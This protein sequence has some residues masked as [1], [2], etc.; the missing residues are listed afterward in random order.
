[1]EDVNYSGYESY[2]GW[3]NVPDEHLTPY[4]HDWAAM[5]ALNISLGMIND[6]GAE[7]VRERHN[8]SAKLCRDMGQEIGLRLFPKNE[9]ISSPT[10]TAFYVPEKFSW[11]EFDGALRE[12]GLAVGGN[13][14]KLAGKVFRIGHMGSQA[15][16]ELVR[17]GMSV[18]RE[19]MGM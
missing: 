2:L 12:R 16:P 5:K 9:S 6:E 17:E 18:I 10:V 8:E 3:K 19:V 4:T 13:Y 15:D 14:G 11:P 1:I 7:A